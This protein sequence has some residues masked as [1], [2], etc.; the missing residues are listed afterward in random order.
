MRCLRLMVMCAVVFL[1]A[2]IARAEIPER[3]Y[4]AVVYKFERR[5]S[6]EPQKIYVVGI[7]LTNR[8]VQVRVSP[9]GA[10]P[11]GEGKWQTTLMPPTK[12]AERE[13]FDVVVNGDFFSHLSGKDAEGAAAL[14]EFSGGTPAAVSGPA[15]TDGKLWG[16]AEKKRAAFLM[17]GN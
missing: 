7:D 13:Q 15:V 5:T 4:P 9:G 2:A 6:P 11:D 14:K 1:A 3:P 12:I 16:A 17:N 8:N 10:D